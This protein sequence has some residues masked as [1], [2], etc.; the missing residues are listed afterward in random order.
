MLSIDDCRRQEVVAAGIEHALFQ[1]RPRRNHPRHFPPN[2]VTL[3]L[4]CRLHL[5]ANRH[6]IAFLDELIAV[7]IQGMVRHPRHH[8]LANFLAA[9]LARQYQFQLA[10]E[11]LGI[12]EEGFVKVPHAIEQHSMG[13]LRLGLHVMTHHRR[14]LLPIHRSIIIAILRRGSRRCSGR[15]LFV[16][17][18]GR[19]RNRGFRRTHNTSRELTRSRFVNDSTA[20]VGGEKF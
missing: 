13:I 14:Q 11:G 15:S 1:Q 5:L 18:R 3:G 17:G 7:A 19:W 10:G 9:I 20:R 16:F 12:L 6:C 2:Q 4:G 8:H